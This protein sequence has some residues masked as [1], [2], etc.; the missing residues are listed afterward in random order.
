MRSLIYTLFCLATSCLAQIPQTVTLQ[1]YLSDAGEPLSGMHTISVRWYQQP[2]GGGW[3]FDE[4]ID[5]V[6]V[7]GLATVIAGS[8]KPF[9]SNLLASA[10]LWLGFSIDGG[11]ELLP[12]TVL[13]S[14]PYAMVA[15]RALV[16]NALAPE[17]T[18]VVT[19]INE[20]AGAVELVAGRGMQVQRKGNTLEFETL[21]PHRGGRVD[22]VPGV[23][24]YRVDVGAPLEQTPTVVATVHT[25]SFVGVWVSDIDLVVGQFTL[26][27]SAPLLQGEWIEWTLL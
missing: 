8:I 23:C 4:D 2:A 12:R 18:G 16:A 22:A 15:Q 6:V 17:V 27:T 10:P 3:V 24:R 9:P 1:V 5:A 25:D 14:V 11:P 20:V 7:D 19:S 26:N 13:T 21:N